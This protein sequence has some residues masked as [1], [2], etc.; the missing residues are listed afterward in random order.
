MLNGWDQ[1]TF[2]APHWFFHPKRQTGKNLPKGKAQVIFPYFFN[3]PLSP[4]TFANRRQKKASCEN[5]T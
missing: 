2:H 3:H 4:Y 5:T 1:A